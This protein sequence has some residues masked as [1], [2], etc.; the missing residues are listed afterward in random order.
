MDFKC[1]TCEYCVELNKHFDVDYVRNNQ[2]AFF[3]HRL[4]AP[5]IYNA[6]NGAYVICKKRFNHELVHR[7]YFG[8][9]VFQIDVCQTGNV[10]RGIAPC[11]SAPKSCK[12]FEVHNA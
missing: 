9:R 6:I 8:D 1:S 5:D 2:K 11:D 12:L 3:E 10:M 7:R 4:F